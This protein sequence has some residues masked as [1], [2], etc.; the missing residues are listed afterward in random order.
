MMKKTRKR[1][2][3][4]L[5]NEGFGFSCL[6][7]LSWLSELFRFPHYV[8][9]ESFDPNWNRAAL[10]SVVLFLIWGWVHL[11]TRRLLR[12]L[13]YLEE[14]PRICSWCR[15]VCH[16]D[17]WLTLEQYFNSHP[18]TQTTHGMCPTCKHEMDELE[19]N[20]SHILSGDPNSKSR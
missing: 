16:N 11:A 9:G 7:V 15:K 18:K 20:E 4:I 1:W 19:K 13:H 12:R 14:F 17:E 3:H 5:W 6:I 10:R 8:F 2:N